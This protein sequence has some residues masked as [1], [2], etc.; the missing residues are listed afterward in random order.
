[1]SEFFQIFVGRSVL[2]I[3][4]FQKKICSRL[5]FLVTELA[6]LSNVMQY[7]SHFCY[8]YL[9]R[10]W[11]HKAVSKKGTIK[12]TLYQSFMV[13]GHRMALI[14]G[15]LLDIESCL[16]CVVCIKIGL[17]SSCS[18]CASFERYCRDAF[19]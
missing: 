8:K 10:L 7:S 13:T 2:K 16:L 15:W 6:R 4:N 18:C 17:L 1:M 14:S 11:P 9:Q 19:N 12:V 3:T 5:P